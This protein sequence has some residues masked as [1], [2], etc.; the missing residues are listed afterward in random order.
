MWISIKIS[1]KFVPKGPINNIPVLVQI[2]AGRRPGNKPLSERLLDHWRIYASVMPVTFRQRNCTNF[3][4]L[5]SRICVNKS[6]HHWFRWCFARCSAPIHYLYQSWLIVDLNIGD[7]FQWNFKMKQFCNKKNNLNVLS[8]KLWSSCVGYNV[9]IKMILCV[10][11]RNVQMC[12]L[13][14]LINFT[15][16]SDKIPTMIDGSLLTQTLKPELLLV[17]YLYV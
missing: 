5:G 8:A 12:L 17:N 13:S 7:K 2:M 15:T 6:R 1:L 3:N 16:T 4:S 14:C 10:C 11:V 9:L